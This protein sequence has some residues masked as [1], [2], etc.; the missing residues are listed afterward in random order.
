MMT[1]TVLWQM[2]VTT[3]RLL[4]DVKHV[5][6]TADAL[7]GRVVGVMEPPWVACDEDRAQEAPSRVARVLLS[8]W[9]PTGDR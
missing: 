6:T 9:V 3:K 8:T 1:R 7:T 2:A 4:G 5:Y